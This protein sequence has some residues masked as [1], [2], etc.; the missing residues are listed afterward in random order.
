MAA[1]IRQHTLRHP[2]LQNP[3]TRLNGG[4][5]LRD[6]PSGRKEAAADTNGPQPHD[7]PLRIPHAFPGLS[8]WR[9]AAV[10]EAAHFSDSQDWDQLIER[11]V[12]HCECSPFQRRD[13]QPRLPGS[14]LW[15]YGDE[16]ASFVAQ[17]AEFVAVGRVTM[18]NVVFQI[19]RPTGIISS[20]SGARSIA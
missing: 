5:E 1:V 3:A 16:I 2:G 14:I 8:F 10:R 11:S 17:I 18:G 12:C 19:C 13:L 15:T 9:P 4:Q 7:V 6:V 20:G